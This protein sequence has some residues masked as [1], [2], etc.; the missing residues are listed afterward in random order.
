MRFVISSARDVSALMRSS[1][2]EIIDRNAVM[3]VSACISASEEFAQHE[4]SLD[5]IAE[6]IAFHVSIFLVALTSFP[7]ML[8]SRGASTTTGSNSSYS[9]ASLPETSLERWTAHY[10]S[11]CHRTPTP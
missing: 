4:A 11:M 5:I 2:I 1:K 6:S 8:F 7:P 3:Q 10:H 9:L